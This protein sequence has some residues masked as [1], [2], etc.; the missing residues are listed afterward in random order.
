[1]KYFKK[2]CGDKLLVGENR[3][4][5]NGSPNTLF[6]IRSLFATLIMSLNLRFL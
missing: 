4:A 6:M 2:Y 3:F 5:P 1:M